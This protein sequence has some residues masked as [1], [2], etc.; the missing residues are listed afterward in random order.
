MIPTLKTSGTDVGVVVKDYED[1]I[2]IK[3]L[4]PR[5][6]WRLMGWIDESIDKVIKLGLSD[7]QMYKPARNSI[8]VQCLA[9]IFL[10]IHEINQRSPN[11]NTLYEAHLKCKADKMLMLTKIIN[12]R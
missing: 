8:V 10:S 2:T 9:D 7:T 1:L 11:V 5:E 6:R 4:K 12:W 3:K